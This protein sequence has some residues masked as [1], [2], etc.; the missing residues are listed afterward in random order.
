MWNPKKPGG[1]MLKWSSLMTWMIWGTLI[2]GSLHLGE[3]HGFIMV[4]ARKKDEYRDIKLH[5]HK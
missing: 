1:S 2:L 3:Y 4:Q 5:N